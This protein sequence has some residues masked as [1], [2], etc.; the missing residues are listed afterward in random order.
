[1]QLYLETII[2]IIQIKEILKHKTNRTENIKSSPIWFIPQSLAM[3]TRC[4]R[5]RIVMCIAM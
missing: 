2:D 5:L 4:A 3:L 1:M